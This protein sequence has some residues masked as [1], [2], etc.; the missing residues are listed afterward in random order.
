MYKGGDRF[1]LEQE[2][3]EPES[4]GEGGGW[5]GHVCT[6][7]TYQHQLNDWLSPSLVVF[8][9]LSQYRLDYY[10]FHS[11]DSYHHCMSDRDHARFNSSVSHLSHPS[12]FTS[13]L[14]PLHHSIWSCT[15]WTKIFVQDCIII[16]S[17]FFNNKLISIYFIFNSIF[18]NIK[19]LSFIQVFL[20]IIIIFIQ[21]ILFKH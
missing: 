19:R 10:W 14:I 20:I 11:F 2:M 9:F 6:C 13:K 3:N 7:Q 4:W 16:I 21:F 17:K 15:E 8:H 1:V 18:S 12:W 5:G